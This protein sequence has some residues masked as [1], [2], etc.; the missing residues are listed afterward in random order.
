MSN[1]EQTTPDVEENVDVTGAAE[2]AASEE[3]GAPEAAADGGD[4]YRGIRGECGHGT[5]EEDR[6]GKED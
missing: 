4:G 6:R 1:E 3:S 2:G 5:P